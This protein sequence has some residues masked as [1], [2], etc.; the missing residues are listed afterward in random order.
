[1]LITALRCIVF[2]FTFE[3]KKKIWK[4]YGEDV[5]ENLQIRK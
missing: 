5:S 3:R 2:C 1:M 4:N